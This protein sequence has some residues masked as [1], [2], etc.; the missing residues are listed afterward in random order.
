M[1]DVRVAGKFLHIRSVILSSHCLHWEFPQFW[2]ESF[3]AS[4]PRF[5]NYP[6]RLSDRHLHKN[7]TLENDFS[8]FY[9][10]QSLLTW[11]KHNFQSISFLFRYIWKHK[12]TLSFKLKL[13]EANPNSK[14]QGLIFDF[15]SCSSHYSRIVRCFVTFYPLSSLQRKRVW[16]S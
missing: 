10:V 7:E 1:C 6:N 2:G 16:R 5:G 11:A 4:Q 15:T 12:Q 3:V 13:A 14:V 8:P 9:K